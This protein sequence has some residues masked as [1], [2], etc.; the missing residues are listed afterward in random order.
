MEL[1]GRPW[2]R[3]VRIGLV[4]VGNEFGSVRELRCWEPRG[5]LIRT[6]ITSPLNQVLG[7]AFALLVYLGIKDRGYF[8][9]R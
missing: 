9:F 2:P 8:V 6:F 1:G 5:F 4:E 3:L 7:L